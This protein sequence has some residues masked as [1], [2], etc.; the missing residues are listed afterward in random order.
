[1]MKLG[2]PVTWT[3]LCNVFFI[4]LWFLFLYVSSTVIYKDSM[5]KSIRFNRLACSWF[6]INHVK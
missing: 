5:F 6:M 1:M 3:K 2:S 4:Y